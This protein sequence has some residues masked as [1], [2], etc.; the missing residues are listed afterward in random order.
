MDSVVKTI[1][2]SKEEARIISEYADFAQESFSKVVKDAI[3]DKLEDEY[4]LKVADAAYEDYLKNP[5]TYSHKE[6]LDELGL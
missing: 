2:F 3:L 6:V 1:R 5:E 4:D